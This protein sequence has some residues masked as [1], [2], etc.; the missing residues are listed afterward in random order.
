MNTMG[1]CDTVPSVLLAVEVN[2]GRV[3]FLIE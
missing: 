1:L 2:Y 3:H